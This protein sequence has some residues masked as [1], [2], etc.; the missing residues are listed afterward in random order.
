MEFHQRKLRYGVQSLSAIVI[1]AVI[2]IAAAAAAQNKP[3]SESKK[4]ATGP[5]QPT[6]GPNPLLQ[7]MNQ[8]P[9][10]Q[11]EFGQLLEKIRAGVHLPADRTQSRLLSLL[12]ESTL[13]YAALPNYGEP[14]QQALK[15]FQQE[16]LQSAV[17]RDWWQHGSMAASGPKFEEALEKFYQLSQYRGTRSS[18]PAAAKARTPPASCWLRNCASPD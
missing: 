6:I 8:Y 4:P 9:G 14:S 3:A 7:E 11:Q 1:G 15:I 17:L 2:L 18:S 13:F 5:S 16:L 10:L 12:P